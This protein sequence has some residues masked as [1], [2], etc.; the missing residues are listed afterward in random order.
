MSIASALEPFARA[1]IVAFALGVAASAVLS[2]AVWGWIRVADTTATTRHVLWWIA[3]A[4]SALLPLM[5]L[6]SSLARVQHHAVPSAV[7]AAAAREPLRAA[8]GLRIGGA[9][10][11]AVQL[12]TRTQPRQPNQ[13]GRAA[14]QSGPVTPYRSTLHVVAVPAQLLEEATT[15]G[16]TPG[17]GLTL[18]IVWF[19]IA[20]MRIGALARRVVALRAVK[21]DAESL[22]EAVVR[23]L[24]RWRQS[25]RAGRR[26]TLRVSAAVDVPVAVGF[27]APVILLPLAIVR[28][29][30]S[31]DIDQIALHEY[32]HLNRYDDW[33][34]LAERA[35]S[36]VFWFNPLI[37]LCVR[38]ISL[39]REVACDDWVVAQTGRAHRYASCLWKLVETTQLP[40]RSILAPGALF[41]SKQIVTRIERLLDSRRNALPRLSPLGALVLGSLAVVLIVAAGLRAPVI[42]IDDLHARKLVAQY[43]PPG[44]QQHGRKTPAAHDVAVGTEGTRNAH[45]L[46]ATEFRRGIPRASFRTLHARAA[47]SQASAPAAEHGRSPQRL[48]PRAAIPIT[49]SDQRGGTSSATVRDAARAHR[50]TRRS[51]AAPAPLA[52]HSLGTQIA[53]SVDD[54]LRDANVD[55]V[56]TA[57][58]AEA[59]GALAHA[60][61][62]RGVQVALADG[63]ITDSAG[64]FVRD[65]PSFHR[66]VLETGVRVEVRRSA[67]SRVDFHGARVTAQHTTTEVH[68]GTLTI[69]GEGSWTDDEG[70]LVT[71]ETPSLD[72]IDVDGSSSLTVGAFDGDR[73]ALAMNG[74]GRIEVSGGS[75]RS[76]TFTISGSG[77]IDVLRLRVNTAAVKIEG[78]GDVTLTAPATL[79]V[80]IDGS[81]DVQLH[82][83]AQTVSQ[84]IN[85]SGAI[86]QK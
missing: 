18:I 39:E 16:R 13:T 42:A 27:R 72:G 21:H 65:F 71:I 41:T 43:R 53:T 70:A 60:H 40:T 73:L 14:A 20:G 69:G 48:A 38:R 30:P 9:P 56:A 31:T 54:A 44:P 25:S 77:D 57:A 81:G 7:V 3:L 61:V 10:Q 12:R 79:A 36:C 22:D 24:R 15:I 8:G 58:L 4:A 80:E 67:R 83:H 33:T 64:G 35:L 1:L 2:A 68:G 5:C 37:A 52:E 49:A 32:A 59:N 29:E 19:A 63:G 75:A 45:L 34:N 28:D 11:R 85:G 6:S 26:A 50:F 76:A 17:F 23:K 84:Q 47:V 51:I 82:G 66:I 74:S 62:G 46:V 78:S 55:G 86:V